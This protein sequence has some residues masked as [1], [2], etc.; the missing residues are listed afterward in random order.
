MWT[1]GL[2]NTSD[3]SGKWI[4]LNGDAEIKDTVTEH[5]RLASRML[6]RAFPVTKKISRATAYVSGLGFFDYAQS[7]FIKGNTSSDHRCVQK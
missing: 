6:R 4:G 7:F 3:W 2:L 5:R 1:M